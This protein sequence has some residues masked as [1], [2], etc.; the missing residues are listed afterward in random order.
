M[1]LAGMPFVSVCG[2]AT[3]SQNF[4]AGEDTSAW[5]S[6][7]TGGDTTAAFLNSTAGGLVAGD[8]GSATQ[9]FSRSFKNNTVGLDLSTAYSISMDVQVNAFDGPAG[10]QFEIIDGDFGTGNAANLRIFTEDIGGGNFTYRWQARNNGANPA[11]VDLGITMDLA[12]PYHVELSIDPESFTYS[13][14]VHLI[15]TAGNI[16]DSGSTSG[17]AF[18]Q[19]VINNNQNGTLLFY[20]QASAGGTVA[21]VDNINIQS[22]PEPSLPLLGAAAALGLSLRR[23]RKHP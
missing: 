7:W 4:E 20:I 12:S 3:I 2:A 13:A 1:L 9:S 5:G 15:D 18:D 11:W 19:N 21:M 17:L 10:G 16:L 22:V 23:G 8:G 6:T 14:A